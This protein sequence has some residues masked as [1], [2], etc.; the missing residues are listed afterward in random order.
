MDAIRQAQSIPV[1]EIRAQHFRDMHA[2][3]VLGPL[4]LDEIIEFKLKL[5]IVARK[6]LM[7]L[8]G[9]PGWLAVNGRAIV[10]DETF[11]RDDP[12]EYQS[13]LAHETVHWLRHLQYVPQRAVTKNEFFAFHA[14]LTPEL[15]AV[16]EWEARETGLRIQMPY[17]EYR[18]IFDDAVELARDRFPSLNG[19]AQ[20][21]VINAVA[22]HF[23]VSAIRAG[24]RMQRE[25]QQV[26]RAD[27]IERDARRQLPAADAGEIRHSGDRR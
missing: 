2:P 27:R 21:F 26:R 9:K 8:T 5:E 20:T 7:R 14:S 1:L 16:L 3:G 4:E 22:E 11:Q 24:I 6:D 18:V 13:F 12:A 10:V 23:G 19:A 15:N 17:G 25:W